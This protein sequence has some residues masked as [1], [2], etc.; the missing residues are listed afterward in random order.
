MNVVTNMY[1]IK[2]GD[3]VRVDD[4]K[5]E[6]LKLFV[7]VGNVY[8]VIEVK[9]KKELKY[10]DKKKD[11]NSYCCKTDRNKCITIEIKYGKQCTSCY[12]VLSKV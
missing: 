3:F 4:I 8:K 6:E 2:V 5:D 1:G 11:K 9:S 7:T 10:C 12:V